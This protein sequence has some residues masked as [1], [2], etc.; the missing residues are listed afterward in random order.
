MRIIKDNRGQVRIYLWNFI[1]VYMAFTILYGHLRK[2]SKRT[3]LPPIS[4]RIPRSH[5]QMNVC[6]SLQMSNDGK[7]AVDPWIAQPDGP[8]TSDDKWLRRQ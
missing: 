4:C 2:E 5:G 1:I 7:Q 8:L 3:P 6:H